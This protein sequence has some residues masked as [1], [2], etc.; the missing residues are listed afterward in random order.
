MPNTFYGLTIAKTGLYAYQTAITTTA[1]NSSNVETEGYSRQQ[2]VR[3]A[4]RPLSLSSK[5]GMLGSGVIVNSIESLRDTYYDTKYRYNNAIYVNQTTKVYYM[6]SIQSYFSEVNANGSTASMDDFFAALSGLSGD[7]GNTTRRTEVASNGNTFTESINYLYDSLQRTQVELNQEIRTIVGQINAYAEELV[8]I[9]RQI[10]TVEVRGENANDLRDKRELIVDKLSQFANVTA[11]EI[12]AEGT[13]NQYIVRLDGAMLVDTYQYYTLEVEASETK[14]NGDDVEGLYDLKWSN[15]QGFAAYSPTLGGKLQS[16]FELRDG[17]NNKNFAGKAQLQVGGTKLTITGAN[18]NKVSELN[19][20]LEKGV[21][22]IG[23]REFEYESYEITG[24]DAVKQEYTYEFTLKKP[25]T[26]GDVDGANQFGNNAMIG[27]PIAYKGIPYYMAQIN[28]FARTFAMEFNE[29]HRDG[30]D[31]YGK[32]EDLNF[33][34]GTTAGDGKEIPLSARDTVD[35]AGNVTT[36]AKVN[37]GS[38]YRLLNA[39]NLKVSDIIMDD[40]RKIACSG[41]KEG[42]DSGVEDADNIKKLL[43]LQKD[44]GMFKQ[45]TPSAFFESFMAVLGVSGQ[46]ANSFTKRQ[47]A[48]LQAVKQQRYSVSGVDKDEEA[49]DLVKFKGA[50]DLCSKVVST[51]NEIYNKLINETGV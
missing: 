50:Y 32:C 33:F 24:Y 48:I 30:K 41:S 17:N 20:P 37:E 31:F 35:A 22:T 43:G 27:R 25:L 38:T 46:E 4:E 10:N 7:I 19:I 45:G 18:I 26:Q 49:V 40:V 47:E 39:G 12:S 28:E 15:G 29:I 14:I 42:V 21:I 11:E 5:Y 23:N 44:T 3:V 2:A 1:H 13:T 51:M 34:T 36:S 6:D 9:T 8:T 16:L